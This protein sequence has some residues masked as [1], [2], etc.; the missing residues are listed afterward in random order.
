MFL[1]ISSTHPHKCSWISTFFLS[2]KLQ[3][4]KENFSLGYINVKICRCLFIETYAVFF[5]PLQPWQ[6]RI[7]N[8]VVNILLKPPCL[9]YFSF[10]LSLCISVFAI[11]K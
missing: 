1:S 6:L 8:H 11:E 2:I 7:K 4:V 3:R 10:L 9:P 5:C